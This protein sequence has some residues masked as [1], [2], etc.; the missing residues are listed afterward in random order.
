M[1]VALTR[2]MPG[3]SMP[4][5]KHLPEV[6]LQ[7]LILHLK[8]LGK[9]FAKFIK[10]GKSHKIIQVPPA[11]SFTLASK[12]NG[13]QLFLQN[14]SGCHGIQGRGD[15]DSTKK[16]VSIETDQ[17]RPRNLTQSWLFRR[18][19]RREDIFLTLRT[20]LSLTAMPRFSSRIFS[21]RDI[22]DIVNYV[23]TLS[24][25]VQPQT[26]PEM[27]VYKTE[28]T[29][30]LNPESPRWKQVTA[31]YFPVG[32]QIMQ[33]DKAP[34]PTADG[35]WVQALYNDAD[36]AF[37]FQWN[38]PT[39]DPILMKTASVTES[40]APP[41]PPELQPDPGSLPPPEEPEPQAI[42]DAFAIQFP[43]PKETAT[44]PYFLNGDDNHPVNLWK[45]VSHPNRTR[46]IYAQGCQHQGDHRP[47][48]QMVQSKI[49][50]R[51]GQYHLVMKR[52]QTTGDANDVQFQ[53]GDTVPIAFN[54]WDGNEK[55]TGSKMALS[56]WFK[57]RLE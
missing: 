21:D 51:Y 57:A 42:P 29:L 5:W 28:G 18:G 23:Y 40:P 33:G 46:E 19:G 20:G 26:V 1:H 14:C 15:G 2:G 31:F 49:V 53:S 32:G 44:L 4:S 52:K 22:W 27:T 6:D 41:L 38:D 54:I 13:R 10:K 55:E 24:P 47:S 45:W 8:T 50:F 36:I 48:S 30:P 7:S 11:P 17:I 9:K 12:E 37:R 43:V 56:S 3:T 35:V 16:I 39:F 34:Y 25:A